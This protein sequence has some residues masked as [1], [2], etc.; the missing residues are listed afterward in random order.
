MF[1]H[2]KGKQRNLPGFE[3]IGFIKPKSKYPQPKNSRYRPPKKFEL[4]YR[5][6][7]LRFRGQLNQWVVSIR[8]KIDYNDLIT[9]QQ[10]EIIE[11][12]LFPQKHGKRWLN[13]REV[14]KKVSG[15]SSSNLKK[16]LVQAM[17][18]VWSNEKNE[19]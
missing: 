3:K 4:I 17:L 7:D 11:L 1:R 15:N 12:Y 13:Q 5:P 6:L 16:P 2:S 9:K 18:K 8:K 19:K 14:M 10:K